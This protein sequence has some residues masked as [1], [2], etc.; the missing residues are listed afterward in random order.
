MKREWL[1]LFTVCWSLFAGSYWVVDQLW[2]LEEEY[3]QI[4]DVPVAKKRIENN[5]TMVIVEL[6]TYNDTILYR[7]SPGH[8]LMTAVSVLLWLPIVA[9]ILYWG[10]KYQQRKDKEKQKDDSI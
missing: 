10:E 1:L 7:P 4:H 9:T 3:V 6:G 2:P 5:Q 8:F